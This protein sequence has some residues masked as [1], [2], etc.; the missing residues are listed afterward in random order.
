MALKSPLI[1]VMERAARRAGRGLIHD[2]GEVEQLQVSAKGPGDFV[3]AADIKSEGTLKEELAKARPDFGLLME[4]GG[5]IAGR[6]GAHRWIVDPLDGTD[7]FLHGIPHFCISIA[8]E[9]RQTVA[10][11]ASTE[12]VAALVYDPIGDDSY[13]A[14]KNQG[15]FLNDRRLRVSGRRRLAEAMISTGLPA[16]RE[17]LAEAFLARYAALTG[18]VGGLR[19]FG[20]AALDLAFVAAGRFDGYWQE[21]LGAWDVAAGVLL[22]RESGGFVSDLEGG[23]GMVESGSVVAANGD[24]HGELLGMLQAAT[25]SSA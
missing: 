11:R 7:N 4:E 25:P 8:V 9:R 10:G 14:D 2:F 19:R 24:L 18:R 16:G 20:S 23:S 1:N 6:D 12:I 15:A 3:S 17:D 22:V 21:G 13:W 5:E